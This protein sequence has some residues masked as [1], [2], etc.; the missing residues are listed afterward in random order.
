MRALT[1]AFIK[2]RLTLPER[3]GAD[4]HSTHLARALSR[5]GHDVRFLVGEH[6]GEAPNGIAM[7]VVGMQPPN[8]A[9]PYEFRGRVRRR[10]YR[11]FATYDGGL[12]AVDLESLDQP[13][14]VVV[15][16]G[17]NL[18]L[19]LCRLKRAV[20]IWYQTDEL[21][22]KKLSRVR[23]P[24]LMA[25]PRKGST[26]H[27]VMAMAL[28]ERLFGRKC[29]DI[30]VVTERE[31]QWMRICAGH[32]RIH[33]V[34]NGVDLDYFRPSTCDVPA[35]RIVFWGRLD[36]PPNIDALR[37]FAQNV[38]PK[39]REAAPDAI[40]TVIGAYPTEEVQRLTVAAG[41]VLHAD[42][43]DL[44]PFVATARVAVFPF[45]SGAG[46][47]N[48]VLE[49]AAMGRALVLS[50]TA[51]AGL[52]GNWAEAAMVCRE[53]NEWVETLHRLL[54]NPSEANELG[55]RARRWVEVNHAWDQTAGAVEE[56]LRRDCHNASK[57]K[58]AAGIGTA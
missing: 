56:I 39:L 10:L 58:R 6:V 8:A 7:S 36:F 42:V 48:K 3:T 4:L 55:R 16:V 2:P 41:A 50:P 24:S 28:Y 23:F 47:K 37:W 1:I 53:P 25:F 44:R 19:L 14:D 29:D 52:R 13:S 34:P 33:V 17:P 21:V 45:V 43:H 30:W 11:Y 27:H 18:P 9:V 5:R 32:N 38:W 49:G 20:H 46:M 54:S 40:L 51:A 12:P 22:L 26:L 57:A 31:R 15:G 35:P